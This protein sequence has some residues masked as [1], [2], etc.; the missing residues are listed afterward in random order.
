MAAA[1]ASRVESWV[2]DQA[3]RLQPWAAAALPQA[4]RWPWPP[5][6]PAWPWPGDRRRQ[7]ERMFREEYDRRT[8][9]LREL[10]RAVRVDTVGELQELLCAMVLAECVYKVRA[11]AISSILLPGSS[12]TLPITMDGSIDRSVPPFFGWRSRMVRL[13]GPCVGH[14][15]NFVAWLVLYLYLTDHEWCMR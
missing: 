14:F 12:C 11:L 4:P 6:R 2:R 8:R 1:L 13:Q 10:C 9:Q 5:R 7:R 3:A 15:L